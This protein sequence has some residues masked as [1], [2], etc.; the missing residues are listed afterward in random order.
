M[1]LVIDDF[2]DGFAMLLATRTGKGRRAALRTVT[3]TIGLKLRR[4]RPTVAGGALVGHLLEAALKLECQFSRETAFRDLLVEDGRVVGVIAERQ[5]RDVTIRAR[6]GVVLS[7]GGFMRD[8][9]LRKE[10]GPDPASTEWTG[11]VPEDTGDALRAAVDI[12]AATALMGEA[13]WMP[14]TIGPDKTGG[15]AGAL[16]GGM[17][18]TPERHLP[19]SIIVDSSGVRYANEAVNYMAVG[20]N[21]YERNETVPA[22]PSWMIVESRHRRRYPLG[23]ALP[24]LTPRSWIKSGY[25][26]KAKT[27]REL[28]TQCG[29]DPERL[30]LTVERFNRMA[31]SGVD[32]DFHRGQ[33]AY[34]RNMGDPTVKPNP[35][36]G[37]ISKPPFY[38]IP[39]Y[40]G[41]VGSVGGLLTDEHARVLRE[42]G[43]P[44]EGLY[45]C[46]CTAAS[47]MGHVYAG[48]GIAI[49][50]SAIFGFIAGEHLAA[51]AQRASA[52]STSPQASARGGQ[53]PV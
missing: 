51:T 44:I 8:E 1:G 6:H 35:C 50:Q 37:P 23:I 43:A 2:N 18:I 49:G 29:I 46:G 25:M 33:S 36:L 21:M 5:G 13:Y 10:Y 48:G 16:A 19:H 28:A 7:A 12:G 47:A 32:A 14:I 45:A 20:R 26:K 17:L 30:A 40:P 27:V 53:Q 52:T 11:T 15:N 9:S 38:A 34:D 3:K 31:E 22:I 41:D 42:D 24:G 39:L 4:A